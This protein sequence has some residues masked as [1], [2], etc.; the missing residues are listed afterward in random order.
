[1]ETKFTELKIEDIYEEIYKIAI[2]T[3]EKSIQLQAWNLLV[4]YKKDLEFKETKE[5]SM[6][7]LISSLSK[8]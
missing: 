5:K 6:K 4:N 3:D 7:E 2:S 8:F 1:M